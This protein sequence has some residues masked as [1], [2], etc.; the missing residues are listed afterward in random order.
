MKHQN[1]PFKLHHTYRN[2]ESSII[3]LVN[4]V[5]SMGAI[6]CAAHRLCSTQDLLH[7]TRQVSSHGPRSHNTC[8]VNHLVHSDVAIVLNYKE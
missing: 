6:Y 1:D 8:N 4:L 3:D 5:V 7:C 2:A